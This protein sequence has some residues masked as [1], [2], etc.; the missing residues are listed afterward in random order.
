MI[1]ATDRP[2]WLIENLRKV[3]SV[4]GFLRSSAVPSMQA[5]TEGR[6][7]GTPDVA[8]A[9]LNITALDEADELWAVVCALVLDHAERARIPV[10]PQIARQWIDT[11]GSVPRV[12]GFATSDPEAINADVFAITQWLVERAWALALG[13]SYTVPVDELVDQIQ[14]LASRIPQAVGYQFKAFQRW[15]CPE[16]YR[17]EVEAVWAEDQL[18]GYECDHCGWE[19]KI[20]RS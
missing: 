20:E 14:K 5:R 9:P 12:R 17:R 18:A 15:A 8:R 10:P 4:I 2:D 1:A 16:C 3:P 19:R 7:S 13:A 11:V 6:V